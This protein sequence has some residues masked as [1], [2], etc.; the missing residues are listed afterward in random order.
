MT[1][2]TALT[3]VAAELALF[4][5]VGFLLFAINDL[6]VDCIYFARRFWRSATLYR[7]YPKA[8]GKILADGD[9]VNEQLRRLRAR[10]RQGVCSETTDDLVIDD[11]R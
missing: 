3:H 11:R 10:H 2:A 9:V 8:F 1:F 7:R 6:A 4:S 5:A